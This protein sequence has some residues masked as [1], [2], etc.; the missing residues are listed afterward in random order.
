MKLKMPPWLPSVLWGLGIILTAFFL[1]KMIDVYLE[2]RMAVS[3]DIIL[4]K[5]EV[6]EVKQ[7]KTITDYQRDIV[8]MFTEGK[9]IGTETPDPTKKKEGEEIPESPVNLVNWDQELSSGGGRIFLKGTIIGSDTAVAFIQVG[10]E[11][12]AL[13]IGQKAGSYYIDRIEKSSVIFKKGNEEIFVSMDMGGRVDTGRVAMP[14][15]TIPPKPEEKNDDLD[16]I[17]ADVGGKKVVDRV[18]FNALLTPPSRLANS[19]KFIPYAKDG[20]P[21][22]IKISYLKGGSF[23]NRVN[24][25]AGD[26]LIKAN[27]S[28]IMSVEDSFKV[29]QMFKNEDHMTLEVDRGGS[30]V[31]IPIEFR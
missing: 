25:Q 13:H 6:K 29:Y 27:N 1:G 23:F 22:G 5:E 3:H 11:D 16:N 10:E 17:V 15:R 26:I 24:M 21:Y 2:S 14:V 20:K 8:P 31:Q 28:E 19:I 18:K 9:T 12:M 7:E 4:A 30:I